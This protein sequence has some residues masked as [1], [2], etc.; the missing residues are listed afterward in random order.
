MEQTSNQHTFL[1]SLTV[2]LGGRR[3]AK[4]FENAMNRSHGASLPC[5]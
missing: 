4:F 3:T 5:H 2:D 1:D